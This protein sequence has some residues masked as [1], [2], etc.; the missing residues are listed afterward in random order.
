MPQVGSTPRPAP[1]V[2]QERVVYIP[3]VGR[4]VVR[5]PTGPEGGPQIQRAPQPQG[6]PRRAA[7]RDN[8]GSGGR[9]ARHAPQAAD[10]RTDARS[11]GPLFTHAARAQLPTQAEPAVPHFSHEV[12]LTAPA[13]D[14]QPAIV[15]PLRGMKSLNREDW[16]R[17]II[18]NEIL[19]PPV[20]QRP[21]HLAARLGL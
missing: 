11:G 14:V 18:M 6:T 12:A 17:A 1:G 20:S 8:T 21:D 16:R 15:H 4:V 3:G 10:S 2:V 7:S 13:D 5:T 19:S 9:G